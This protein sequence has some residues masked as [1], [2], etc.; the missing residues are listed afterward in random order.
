M[1]GNALGQPL[2]EPDKKKPATSAP[3]RIVSTVKRMLGMNAGAAIQV[4]GDSDLMAFLAK[5]CNPIPGDDI[6]GYVT[7]GR[8]VAVH[9]TSCPNVQNLLYEPERR[10]DV[11]WAESSGTQFT[12]SLIIRTQNRPGMLADIT[13]VISEA[14]SNIR[15]LASQP[16]NL[17]ARVEATLEILNRKQLERISPTSRRFPECLGLSVCIAFDRALFFLVQLPNRRL[18]EDSPL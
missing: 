8:G 16:D 13:S 11:G 5:C 17:N 14:G 12:V 7:R 4:R 9:A 10:I 6:V 1:L 15:T 2:G 18:L 3:A